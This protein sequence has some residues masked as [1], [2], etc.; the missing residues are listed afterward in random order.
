VIS[1]STQNLKTE[2]FKRKMR[3][4]KE[5]MEEITN[6]W[7]PL[8]QQRPQNIF[9]NKKKRIRKCLEH[10]EATFNNLFKTGYIEK[11]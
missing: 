9:N 7:N 2:V 10:N 1:I 6:C 5:L 4:L 11:T 3:T 8:D